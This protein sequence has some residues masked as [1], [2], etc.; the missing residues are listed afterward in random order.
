MWR[1]LVPSSNSYDWIIVG[2]GLVGTSIA[3]GLIQQRPDLRILVLDGADTDHRASVGNFGLIWVQGKGYNF[4]AYANWSLQGADLWPQFAQRLSQ[5]SQI[6]LAYQRQG[7]LEFAL[8][9]QHL[10]ALSDEMAAVACHT[11]GGFQYSLLDRAQALALQPGLGESVSGAV[12][13]PHDGQVN[14]LSLLS[15]LQKVMQSQ[16]VVYRPRCKV[17][18][19]DATDTGFKVAG[20]TGKNIVLC[21]GLDNERLGR[22]LGMHLPVA[23]IKGQ[24]LITERTTPGLLP[25]ASPQIRQTAEGTIQVGGS[26]EHSGLDDRSSFEVM[27]TIARD[28]VALMPALASLKMVRSWGALRVM[29]PD[30]A[31]IYQK[32]GTH[33]G[34]YGVCCHSGVS[35]AAAHAGPLSLWLLNALDQDQQTLIEAMN[36]DRFT[37]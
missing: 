20:A 13:S 15:A 34:A 23:P 19:V 25:Y 8:S 24:I 26:H 17:D 35:L 36:N 7:G 3:Y 11:Q 31:P 10:S 22:Q 33:K 9:P 37:V 27:Q 30:G 4:P 32:S 16:G 12:Y 21:A 2:G 14:P 6:N 28:A 5:Q 1:H 18:D 29:S